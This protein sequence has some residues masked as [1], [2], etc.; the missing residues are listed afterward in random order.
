VAH[1]LPVLARKLRDPVAL[2]VL[3]KAFDRGLQWAKPSR[4]PV[5][6]CAGGTAIRAE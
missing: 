4:H 3:M 5:A 6:R 2:V 1:V